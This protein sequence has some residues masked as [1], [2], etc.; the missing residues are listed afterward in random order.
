ME[1]FF[2][3]AAAAADTQPDRFFTISTIKAAE[4]GATGFSKH[5]AAKRCSRSE[6]GTF[7]NVAH[8]DRMVRW[9][10]RNNKKSYNGL[11]Q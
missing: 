8:L 2:Q 11:R 9:E 5:L 1:S 7:W 6:A 3:T 4:V 10:L